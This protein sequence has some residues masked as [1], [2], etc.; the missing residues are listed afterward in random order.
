MDYQLVEEEAIEH[1]N[2]YFEVRINPDD[3]RPQRVFFVSNE[4]NLEDVARDIL[5]KYAP[6][7]EHW[8]LIPHRKH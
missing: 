4:E 7:A 1:K 2:E 5:Q 3:A 6:E 8:T